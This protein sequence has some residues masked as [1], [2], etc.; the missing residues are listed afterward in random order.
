MEMRAPSKEMAAMMLTVAV[1]PDKMATPWG[2]TQ[3][4]HA[5]QRCENCNALFT[6]RIWLTDAHR[7]PR[8]FRE[9]CP[10][11]GMF[12]RFRGDRRR[13]ARQTVGS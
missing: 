10:N 9:F 1:E 7:D 2:R 6:C 5:V 13:R 4:Q 3:L 12:E 11:A 8:A